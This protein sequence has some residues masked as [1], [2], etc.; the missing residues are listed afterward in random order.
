M[1]SAKSLFK[2]ISII[3]LGLIGGSW[4]RALERS[5]FPAQRIGFDR[6]DVLDQ[7]IKS[8]AVHEG[9]GDLATA[10]HDA[11]LVI[12]AAPVGAILNLVAQLKPHISPNALV[13]DTG[14]TKRVICER[15]KELFGKQSLFLGGH[16]IAG[17]EKSGFDHADASI[18]KNACYALT[19][20]SPDHMAEERV[21][22]FVALLES[23]G[24]RPYVTDAAG[25]DLAVAFLSHLPQLISSGLASLMDEAIA[26]QRFPLELAGS[27]FRDLTRLA[28]SPYNLWR[29]IC[30]TNTENIQ[31]AL[32]TMIEKLEN[33]K[34]ELSSRE[35]EREFAQARHL[36][37]RLRKCS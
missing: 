1:E 29:D 37:D 24:A 20:L 34:S 8:G 22:A 32:D 17:K 2:K 14:S 11:D 21:K 9:A 5:N 3:G 23:I 16:P 12:L 25:H 15:A 30:L 27:G 6:P 26:G 13:T 28:D 19:P 36:R 33:M 31:A 18:F 7:A 10:V 4:A 35:L